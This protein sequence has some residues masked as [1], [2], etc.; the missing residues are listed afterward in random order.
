MNRTNR[1]ETNTHETSPASSRRSR[2]GIMLIVL[3]GVF[4][5][6]IFAVPFAPLT[7][8]QKSI[9]AGGLFAAVQVS[10]WTGAALAGP[11]VVGVIKG[12]FARKPRDEEPAK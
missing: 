4:W 1:P 7:I 12:W 9:F 10:W 3:S 8:G 2:L 11:Q 5:F 6:S